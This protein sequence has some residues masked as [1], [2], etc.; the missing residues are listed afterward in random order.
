MQEDP[1]KDKADPKTG[2]YDKDQFVHYLTHCKSEK[3]PFAVF[4]LNICNVK[5]VNQKHG[6]AIG[7][8]FI[9]KA[10]TLAKSWFDDPD[11][12]VFRTFG[13]KL[14]VVKTNCDHKGANAVR[15]SLNAH[16]NKERIRYKDIKETIHISIGYA[17]TDVT[18]YADLVRQA[19]ASEKLDR[20]LWYREH[21]EEEYDRYHNITDMPHSSA[22]LMMA[23]NHEAEILERIL[24]NKLLKARSLVDE[25]DRNKVSEA[26]KL[27]LLALRDEITKKVS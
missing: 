10:I 23:T 1:L 7:D 26:V 12:K 9:G 21:P 8:I 6:W 19:D 13:D 4:I 2:L 24:R 27:D 25:I 20:V 3:I 22:T 15:A 5:R 18:P 14:H 16:Q 17:A 11:S